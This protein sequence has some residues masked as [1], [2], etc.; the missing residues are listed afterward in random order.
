MR[1]WTACWFAKL[2]PNHT[3]VRVSRWAPRGRSGHKSLG[4]LA[5]GS[6]FKSVSPAEYLVRY[7]AILDKLDAGKI[8]DD[9]LAL[10][11]NPTMLC[12]ESAKDIQAGKLWCHRHL[13]AKWLEDCLGIK[14]E[15]VDHPDLDRFAL[16]RGL[17]IPTPSYTANQRSLALA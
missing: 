9:L 14:I 7:N 15:E 16:L 3:P 1:I 11:P 8:R 2:P 12:F 6:W 17:G 4:I 13:A 5:P 10:G